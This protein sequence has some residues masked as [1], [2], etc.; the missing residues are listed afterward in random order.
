[1]SADL[2]PLVRASFLVREVEVRGR[3]VWRLAVLLPAIGG[4]AIL[5]GGFAIA[6]LWACICLLSS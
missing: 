3:R 2:Q 5:I 4:T 1:M 6:F